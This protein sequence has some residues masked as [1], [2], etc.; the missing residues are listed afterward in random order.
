MTAKL[1]QVQTDTLA[2]LAEQL[3]AVK[4]LLEKRAQTLAEQ[5][6]PLSPIEELGVPNNLREASLRLGYAIRCL[7]HDGEHLELWGND[8]EPGAPDTHPRRGPYVPDDR[9][10]AIPRMLNEWK[11]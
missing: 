3:A 9:F 8:G 1:P 6:L 11:P 5:D 10:H 7:D 4:Q 2:L